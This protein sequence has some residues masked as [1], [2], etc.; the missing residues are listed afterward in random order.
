MRAGRFRRRRTRPSWRFARETIGL[1]FVAGAPAPAPSSARVL[2]LREVLRWQATEVAALLE[3]SVGLGE[4]RA[5][6]RPGDPRRPRPWMRSARPPSRRHDELLTRYVDAV[7]KR[8][9]IARCRG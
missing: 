3:T 1:A 5:P 6:A 2:I 9:D 8:Y 7:P 4:Q